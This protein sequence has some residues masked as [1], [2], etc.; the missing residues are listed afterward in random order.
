MDTRNGMSCLDCTCITFKRLYIYLRYRKERL[1][2]E[3]LCAA[4]KATNQ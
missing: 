3:R 2:Y 1:D 4:D